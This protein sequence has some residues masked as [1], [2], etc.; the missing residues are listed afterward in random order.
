MTTTRQN[1]F[2]VKL[3]LNRGKVPHLMTG[4]SG[5]DMATIQGYILDE[6][7]AISAIDTAWSDKGVAV[8]IKSSGKALS[9]R[10]IR[11][12]EIP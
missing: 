7:K 10:Q 1:I 12:E 5:R 6:G 11:G 8:S 3:A 2:D 9:Y 4:Y